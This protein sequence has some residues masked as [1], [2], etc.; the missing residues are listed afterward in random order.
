MIILTGV[1]KSS[2][3]NT[4]FT[5]NG[6]GG[7]RIGGNSRNIAFMGCLFG[8]GG[9]ENDGP[10]QQRGINIEDTST[11]IVVLSSTFSGNTVSNIGGSSGTYR[12][13][14]N[15]GVTDTPSLLYGTT[16]QRPVSPIVPVEYYDTTLGLPV[17][18]NTTTSTWK[19]ADG[20]NT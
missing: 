1:N 20:T 14:A 17:W 18:W 19:R 2:F 12:A 3:T 4:R 11:S 8:E 9:I 10:T 5:N 15:F 16:A 7:C 6:E 13:F